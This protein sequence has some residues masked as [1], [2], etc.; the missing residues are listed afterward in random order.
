VESEALVETR[1]EALVASI[2]PLPVAQQVEQVTSERGQAH[3]EVPV[4]LAE[5]VDSTHLVKVSSVDFSG[6]RPTKV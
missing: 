5:R 4:K 6:Y 1:A 3:W 2:K